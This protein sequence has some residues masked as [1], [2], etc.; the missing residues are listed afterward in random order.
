MTDLSFYSVIGGLVF[1][2]LGVLEFALA[3][4]SLYPVLRLRHEQAKLTQTHG[5]EP[6]RIMTLIKVQSLL[7]MPVLGFLLG[8]RWKGMIG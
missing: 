2:G 1:L 5:I 4:R 7:V 3:R 8:G 6:N